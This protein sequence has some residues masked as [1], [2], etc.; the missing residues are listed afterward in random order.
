MGIGPRQRNM[1]K[2]IE[3]QFV[4]FPIA[5][6]AL[7][8]MDARGSDGGDAHAIAHKHYDIACALTFRLRLCLC[9]GGGTLKS[10]IAGL[11]R[12]KSFCFGSIRGKTAKG[13]RKQRRAERQDHTAAGAEGKA[14]A[15]RRIPRKEQAGG[16]GTAPVSCQCDDIWGRSGE[17]TGSAR[18]DTQSRNRS[19]ILTSVMHWSC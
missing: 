15:H 18:G 2:G 10:R 17:K 13:G 6:Q 5:P 3:R 19:C 12:R 11:N 8:R 1:G 4:A 16:E 14:G 7:A 9:L